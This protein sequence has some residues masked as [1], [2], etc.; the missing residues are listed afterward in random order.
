MVMFPYDRYTP[1]Q[2][3]HKTKIQS[4]KHK[5]YGINCFIPTN[6]DNYMYGRY[7]KNQLK[8]IN[9]FC[10]KEKLNCSNFIENLY[11]SNCAEL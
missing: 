6:K 2:D 3:V 11:T 1:E 4:N 9:T 5:W 10:R 8:F 7:Q